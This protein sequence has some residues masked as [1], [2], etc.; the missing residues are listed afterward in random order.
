MM[1]STVI[2]IGLESPTLGLA[3]VFKLLNLIFGKRSEPEDGPTPGLLIT[4]CLMIRPV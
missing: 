1:E 2:D 3:G 4:L